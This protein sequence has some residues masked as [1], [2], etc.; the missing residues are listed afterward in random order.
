[1]FVSNFA[2]FGMAFLSDLGAFAMAKVVLIFEYK[3]NN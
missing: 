1:M 2:F 3:K